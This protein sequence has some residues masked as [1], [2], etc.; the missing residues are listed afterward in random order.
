[1]EELAKD[2]YVAEDRYLVRRCGD[3]VSNDSTKDDGLFGLHANHGR[4]FSFVNDWRVECGVSNQ[5]VCR[6]VDV[7]RHVAIGRDSRC[8]RENNSNV[9]RRVRIDN[10]T[11][12]V[13]SA[14]RDV[15]DA[16]ADVDNALNVI[17][18]K[19]PGRRQNVELR[20]RLD[21]ID[22]RRKVLATDCVHQTLQRISG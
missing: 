17:R 11:S 21:C 6:L 14:T 9:N 22:Q 20:V 3:A 7:H 12:G 18:G 2:W 19:D 15:R 16:L 4:S 10:G 8:N 1:M 13:G 5:V